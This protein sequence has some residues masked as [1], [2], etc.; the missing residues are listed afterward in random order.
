[1]GIV[2]WGEDGRTVFADVTRAGMGLCLYDPSQSAPEQFQ[3]RARQQGLTC[4]PG[5]QREPIL[6]ILHTRTGLRLI[7]EADLTVTELL[8]AALGHAAARIGHD[9]VVDLSSLA[10]ADISALRALFEA[11]GQLR[12]G[13]RLV[14]RS[15]TPT[16]RKAM[17]A[18]GWD[19]GPAIGLEP[20]LRSA[21]A[22]PEPD[23]SAVS[24]SLDPWQ[25]GATIEVALAVL[26]GYQASAVS[27][28]VRTAVLDAVTRANTVAERTTV[29]V[30]VVVTGIV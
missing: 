16:M 5:S 19:S 9:I 18:L 17:A 7:G 11:A 12:E 6:Q 8:A 10:F 21:G 25:E 3:E 24:I 4:G 2:S 22:D 13:C 1:M 20:P 27:R 30:G 23:E 14:L 28:Q 15:P 26:A 29:S